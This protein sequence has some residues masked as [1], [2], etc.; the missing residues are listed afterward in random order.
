MTHYLE[1]YLVFR[2][3][4]KV[5]SSFSSGIDCDQIQRRGWEGHAGNLTPQVAG[6]TG[7]WG[8]GAGAVSCLLQGEARVTPPGGPENICPC[9]AP[10]W[11]S[12]VTPGQT[13]TTA[14]LLSAVSST[15]KQ[16]PPVPGT[17]RH[18]LCISPSPS[19]HSLAPLVSLWT[20][21]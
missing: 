21:L 13:Q 2:F 11:P 9:L 18:G 7:R 10:R 19:P 4:K 12:C 14:A 6:E 3:L 8:G 17:I 20:S 5:T 1:S 16:G 15:G